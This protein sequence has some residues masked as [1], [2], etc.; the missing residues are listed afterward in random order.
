[1]R[2]SSLVNVVMVVDDDELA[3]TVIKAAYTY[4]PS[5]RVVECDN[6]ND[7]EKLYQE[8][9]PDVLFLDIHLP[10]LDGLSLLS[11]IL[12]CDPEAYIVLIS[13]DSIGDNVTKGIALGAKGFITK[14]V[15]KKHLLEYYNRCSTVR[16]QD[17][18]GVA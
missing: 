2:G 14:P 9:F 11:R 6:G 1:V 4:D 10:G 15:S 3:R 8:N 13:A 5:C 7:V 18:T 16:F 12:K 17:K